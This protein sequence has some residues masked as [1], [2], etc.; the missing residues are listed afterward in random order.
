MPY[1]HTE[2]A[3]LTD[4]QSLSAAACK[5]GYGTVVAVGG[6]GTINNVLCGMY[7]R[8]RPIS[9]ARLG[10]LYS[11]TSPDFCK[12]YGVPVALN[13]GLDALKEGHVTDIRPGW[14]RFATSPISST[15]LAEAERNGNLRD[16]V[17]ACCANVGLGADLA[18]AANSGIRK[19]MGDVLGTFLS[20]GKILTAYKPKQVSVE[21]D[22]ARTAYAS[23][24]N[25]SVGK[26]VHVASGI[27]IQNTL[28]PDEGR[29]Y[30]LA[31]KDLT[32][33]RVPFCLRSIYS[34]KPIPEDDIFE[35]GYAETVTLTGEGAVR[36][37]FDGDPAGYLPCRITSAS[38]TLH[39][40][41][42]R[43]DA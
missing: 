10:I 35:F 43:R 8:G 9:A 4:A 1:D 30:T 20:L 33:R 37:E 32:A 16:A 28:R 36:V 14:I 3:S 31:V 18:E 25:L 19:R 11:G 13:E 27:K 7:D 15:S 22:G 40:I 41:T 23:L 39:L 42:G 38:D 29:F 24:H 21:I 26:T 5:D 34:G 17:F 2:T 6:D 12:S